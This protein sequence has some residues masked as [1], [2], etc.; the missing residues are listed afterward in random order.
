[1]V[2][3]SDVW[4][5]GVIV[6]GAR[7]HLLNRL[8]AGAAVVLATSAAAAAQSPA[9]STRAQDP[10][11]GG[12]RYQLR[13]MEGV[14]ESAVQHGAQVVAVQL[15]R[16]SP[17]LMAFSGPARARGY[18][19]DGYGVFFS[20]DVP[21]VR[22]SVV[23]SMRTLERS[24]LDMSSALQ[25]LRRAIETQNDLRTKREL[26]QALQLVELRVGPVGTRPQAPG[27]GAPPEDAAA[28][29]AVVD[30]PAAA[31]DPGEA[32]EREVTAALVDAM[33]DYSLPLTIGPDEWLTVAARDNDDRLVASELGDTVTITLRLRGSDLAAFRAGRLTRDEA[34][35]RVEVREN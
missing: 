21:A 3:R 14:L 16:V 30:A 25:S 6:M 32:Y 8:L 11:A 20:V 27:G 28:S 35:Q 31:R 33:V 22:R 34:R 5:G 23:W 10:Q 24:G 1:M 18:R 4:N 7:M 17:D 12:S 9:L 26:E 2:V 29:S 13:V 19:L 15:R